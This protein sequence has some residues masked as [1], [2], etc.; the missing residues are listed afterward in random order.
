M[1][2]S[3]SGIVVFPPRPAGD[4]QLAVDDH[5]SSADPCPWQL[6]LKT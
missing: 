6:E 4:Y 2:A 1:E 5:V 3:Q